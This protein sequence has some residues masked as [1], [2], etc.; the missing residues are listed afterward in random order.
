MSGLELIGG[1][2]LAVLIVVALLHATG[3]IKITAEWKD[4]E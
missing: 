1:I 2:T 4:S 3:Q